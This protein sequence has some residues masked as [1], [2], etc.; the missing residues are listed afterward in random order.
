MLKPTIYDIKYNT[1][2]NFFDRG[3]LRFFGQTMKDFKVKKSPS[4]RLY[5]YAPI[6]VDRK[7]SG[8]TFREVT[9]TLYYKL[10]V[11]PKPEGVWCWTLQAILDYIA[12]N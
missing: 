10:N 9:G 7:V 6:R 4:D 8:W 3:T 1:T 11:V 5:I 2:G 12:E